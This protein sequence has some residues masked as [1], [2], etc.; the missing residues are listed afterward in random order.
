MKISSKTGHK[1]ININATT[2]K[3]NSNSLQNVESKPKL[4]SLRNRRLK[5]KK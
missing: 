3:L 4:Q 2:Q 1:V 5:K